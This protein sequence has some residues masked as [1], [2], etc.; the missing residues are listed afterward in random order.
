MKQVIISLM[1]QTLLSFAV[2]MVL[3]VV[4]Y[5][6]V[7]YYYLRKYHKKGDCAEE[8]VSI[9]SMAKMIAHSWQSELSR[10]IYLWSKRPKLWW[11]RLWI[12]K[13][14]FHNS[15]SLDSRALLAMNDEEK[16]RYTKD[17]TK[18]R[19]IAHDRDFI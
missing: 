18:R 1:M 4:V 14:E 10:K 15:L 3:G 2:S 5:V 16:E 9:L 19:Q 8:M 6:C 11:H 7:I 13:D 17:L 12:R